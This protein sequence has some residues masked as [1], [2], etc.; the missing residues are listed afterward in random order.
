MGW[1]SDALSGVCDFVSSAFDTFCNGVSLVVDSFSGLARTIG[2]GIKEICDKIGTEGMLLI[3]SIALSL[4]IPGFGLP[5]LLTLIQ[6]VG[7][8]AKILNVG[9]KDSPEEVGMKTEIAEKKP[10]DFE[11]TE[12]YLRY[13]NEEVTLEPD[14]IDKLTPEDRA[15][16]GLIGS[17]LDI[18][19]IH[20]KYHIELSPDFLRDVTIMKMSG[21]EIGSYV[22]DF[23]EKGITKMQDMTDYLRGNAINTEKGTISSSM[24]DTMRSLY[25]EMSEEQLEN[26]L[27][28]MENELRNNNI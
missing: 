4:I 26:K 11:T 3:G 5:E 23:A 1:F 17:A 20:E 12:E 22:K 2:D 7:Q 15:K 14:A 10:D 13:L 19:A 21:E 16:Y 9:G 25:P 27:S 24:L 18:Q 28:E 8:V 6:I